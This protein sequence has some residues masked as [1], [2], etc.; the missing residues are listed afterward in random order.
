MRKLRVLLIG[1]FAMMIL[2]IGSCAVTATPQDVYYD[3]LYET[4]YLYDSDITI[5]I[6]NGIPHFY[7]DVI[8]YY[9]YDGYY[10]YPRYYNNRY[11]FYRYHRPLPPPHWFSGTIRVG[12]RGG[13][14]FRHDNRF[15]H[16]QEHKFHNGYSDRRGNHVTYGNNRPTNRGGVNNGRPAQPTTPR[17]TPQARP[18]GGVTRTIP[19]GNATRVTP[20]VGSARGATNGGAVRGGGRR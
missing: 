9:F 5:I 7:G 2:S 16:Y 6:N 15:R 20:N 13:Y 3:D 1:I 10:Y 18:N 19:N 11:F 4:S 12:R 17:V 8:A 14:D